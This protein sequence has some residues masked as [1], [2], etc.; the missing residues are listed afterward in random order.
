MN[1]VGEFLNLKRVAFFLKEGLY[2]IVQNLGMR[3]GNGGN[4]DLL[5][6]RVAVV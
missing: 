3:G 5:I 4:G 1:V 6:I 2:S